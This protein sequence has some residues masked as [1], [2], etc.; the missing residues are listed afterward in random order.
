MQSKF[1]LKVAKCDFVNN[2]KFYNFYG[3]CVLSS[4]EK[5]Y[6]LAYQDFGAP[7]LWKLVDARANS[8]YGNALEFIF[9]SKP[10]DALHRHSKLSIL[11]PF[12]HLGAYRMNHCFA[13]QPA[14]TSY[15]SRPNRHISNFVALCLDF[16]STLAHNGKGYTSSVI[17]YAI[18]RVDNGIHP[19]F[20]D[21]TIL[22]SY[23]LV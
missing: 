18:C 4:C 7:V 9:I 2:T 23:S 12:T 22:Q 6:S 1:F 16:P 13:G 3:S 15:D 5:F 14:G 8:W 10:E 21:V 20:C 19:P 17:E 11:I